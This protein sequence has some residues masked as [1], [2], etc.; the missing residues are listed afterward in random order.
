MPETRP[1]TSS[2]SSV[3]PRREPPRRAPLTPPAAGL[4]PR[5]RAWVEVDEAAI[6][7]NARRVKRFLSPGTELMAV[8]KA[9][10]YGHGALPVARAAL[11]G[12]ATAL[13]AHAVSRPFA[14]GWGRPRTG[15]LRPVP[16]LTGQ[17]IVRKIRTGAGWDG[18]AP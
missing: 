12:G 9:D 8:V 7:G 16:V 14:T 10:G 15:T 2:I 4:H 17:V 13:G 1:I 5:Q 6:T 18:A 3:P 11:A